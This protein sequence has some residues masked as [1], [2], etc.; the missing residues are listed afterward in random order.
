MASR[1]PPVDVVL[2]MNFSYWLFRERTT[3][4]HYFERVRAGLADDGILF[5]DAYG[6]YDCIRVTKDR[7]KHGD[8]T[9]IW[10]Q[11][12]FDPITHYMRCH[13]HF[14]FPDG[15]SLRNAFTYEWRLWGLPEIKELLLEAGFACVTIYWQGTDEQTGEANGVFEPAEHGEADPAWIV[16][17][18]A[19]KGN[20]APEQPR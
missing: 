1:L 12:A 4:R 18:V 10:D 13:I 14:R 7:H 19:D 20:P 6:G 5:L 16:Y 17:I 8:F 3:L 15:S 2:A 9:Y 11:A